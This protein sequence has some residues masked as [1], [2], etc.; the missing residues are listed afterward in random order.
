MPPI[1]TISK[2]VNDDISP[3]KGADLRLYFYNL[4]TFYPKDQIPQIL[5]VMQI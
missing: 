3:Q 5:W 4:F 2:I 1:E